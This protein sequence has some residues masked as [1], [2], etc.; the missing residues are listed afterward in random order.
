MTGGRTYW[1]IKDGMW[2]GFLIE[3]EQARLDELTILQLGH[4]GRV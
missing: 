2:V 4:F 3:H 1:G